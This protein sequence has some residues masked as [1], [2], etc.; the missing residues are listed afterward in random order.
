M[1]K[2]LI[3]LL[4]FFTISLSSCGSLP[5]ENISNQ[6]LITMME[7]HPEYQYIDV[8]LPMELTT[9]Y[10]VGMIDG[11]VN[12]QLEESVGF[13]VSRSL[14]NQFDKNIPVVIMCNSGNRSV[15]ASEIFIEE[16][17]ETVYNLEYGIQGWLEEGLD[18]VF[19]D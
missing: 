12:V 9:S 10:G 11:F 16:G 7:D 19:S 5:Y 1:K 14:L 3:L 15:T 4:L 6:E 13:A 2:I 18:V 8:R 17:F